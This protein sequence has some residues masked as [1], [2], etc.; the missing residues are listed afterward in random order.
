V[1]IFNTSNQPGLPDGASLSISELNVT[2]QGDFTT[3]HTFTVMLS[4]KDFNTPT[5]TPLLV[6]STGSVTW[7][8]GTIL[9][10]LGLLQ[11]FAD[12]GN[13]LFADLVTANAGASSTPGPQIALRL[14]N[15]TTNF[16]PDPATSVLDRI[17]DFSMSIGVGVTVQRAR[18]QFNVSADNT[19]TAPEPASI[20]MLGIGAFGITGYGWRRRRQSVE[21]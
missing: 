19:V 2:S 10:D 13:A 20:A 21:I 3:P 4:D 12:S 15:Q 11:S 14:P 7:K 18:A 1:S 8:G 6:T 9:G 5:G 16:Q 17:G